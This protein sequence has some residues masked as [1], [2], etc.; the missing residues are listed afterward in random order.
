MIQ[1]RL[2][3]T[4]PKAQCANR[5]RQILQAQAPG[6]EVLGQPRDCSQAPGCHWLQALPPHQTGAVLAL[7]SDAVE[8]LE[9]TRHAF[10]SAQLAQ[11]RK[12]LNRMLEDLSDNPE[13]G[14]TTL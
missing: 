1:T 5:V 4:L 9:Q 13:S 10:K 8:V 14:K 2:L 6:C 7:L 3:V 12:R 11:L